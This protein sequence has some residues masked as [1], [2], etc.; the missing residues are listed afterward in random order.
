MSNVILFI[1]SEESKEIVITNGSGIKWFSIVMVF[2]EDKFCNQMVKA[3]F[4][5]WS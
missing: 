3:Q 2:G 1:H 5:A 4:R